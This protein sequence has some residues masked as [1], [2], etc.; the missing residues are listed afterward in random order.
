[1]KKILSTFFALSYFSFAQEATSEAEKKTPETEADTP[2]AKKP[3]FLVELEALTKEQRTKYLTHY[4][5]ADQ[6]FK[7]KRVFECLDEIHQL[8]QIYDG[9][10]A[11]LN[12]QG[13]CYVEFRN[14][15]KARKAFN[16]ALK[17]S[18]ESFNISFNL[19]EIDFVTKDYKKAL[20]QLEELQK[21]L[22]EAN[23]K[24]ASSMSP[25]IDF[26]VLLCKL[27]TDD[28]EGARKM[29]EGTD[30]LDD[31]P[32]FYYG[33]AA[34][35]YDS[36]NSNEAEIWLARAGRIFRNETLIAPWQDT[37]IEFGYIK[38]FYGGDLEDSEK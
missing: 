8:H 13:A 19:A 36:D 21:R 37:L 28:K 27:K 17:S 24:G 26:K 11:S 22:G 14:F 5:K 35:E 38:S 6:L 7:Q 4:Q 20:S 18:P 31:S 9:N 25:L 32:F 3:Q 33:H 2:A 15:S 34:F 16:K 29:L 10:P 12:L 30:F 23:N 1:M